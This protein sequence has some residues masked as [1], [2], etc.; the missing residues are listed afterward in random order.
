MKHIDVLAAFFVTRLYTFDIVV[1][2]NLFGDILTDLGGTA[3]GFLR[4]RY[5][6]FR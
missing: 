5:T 1:A 2:S 4:F 6:V 3:C